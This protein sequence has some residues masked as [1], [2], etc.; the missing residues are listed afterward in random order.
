MFT[1]ADNFDESQKVLLCVFILQ[2]T[3][4]GLHTS[5]KNANI[6]SRVVKMC[7]AFLA[8]RCE[9]DA[10][11]QQLLTS[12]TFAPKNIN[13]VML[14]MNA[15]FLSLHRIRFSFVEGQK[16]VSCYRFTLFGRVPSNSNCLSN[17]SPYLFKKDS[18]HTVDEQSKALKL[19]S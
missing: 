13:Q 9:S 15:T 11:L 2:K 7:H 12:D 18:K 19:F 1:K 4:E 16:R 5:S 17:D 3:I 10:D 14:L 8:L 6:R